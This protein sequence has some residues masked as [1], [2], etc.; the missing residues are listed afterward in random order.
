MP[1]HQYNSVSGEG[2]DISNRFLLSLT[3]FL[4]ILLSLPH[5]QSV[6]EEPFELVV[7]QH[8]L[9]PGAHLVDVLRKTFNIPDH[10]IFNEYLNL[11]HE[12]NPE[13]KDLSNLADHQ[14]ILIPLALPPKNEN[15]RIVIM[16]PGR[17][18]KAVPS[19]P[20]QKKPVYS[21]PMHE[22]TTP[23]EKIDLTRILSEDFIPLLDESDAAVQQEGTHEFPDFEGSQLSVNT[24]T[25]PI[26]QLKNNTFII[27]DPLNRFPSELKDVIQSNWSNYKF[28]PSGKEQGLESI[29]DQIIKDMSFFKA[30][31]GGEP[32]VRG[33]DVLV[34]ISADWLICPDSE[35]QDVFVV[36]LIYSPEH[37]TLSQIKNYLES[38]SI[39]IIDVRLYK[40]GEEET[41]PLGETKEET[42]EPLSEISKLDISDK[43]DFLDTLLMLAGEEYLKNVPI[44]I[45]S[46]DSNGLAL[47]VTIDRT[48]VKN[49][50]KH[51]IYVQDKSPKLLGLLKKQGFPLLKLSADDDAVST[52]KKVLDFLKIR[53]QSPMITF[54]ASSAGKKSKISIHIP[55]ILFEKSGRNVFLT[56]LELTQS[57]ITFL[58]HK[59]ILPAIYQ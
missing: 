17:I 27:L 19:T 33:K 9:L 4:F 59:N 58:T 34:K 5:N 22:K 56:H 29:L 49:G 13:V 6:A 55:G 32:L 42:K 53:T 23:V 37:K 54:A 18:T 43:L 50:K 36:N 28:I 10:L 12:I 45:Y 11:I 35:S 51:L 25:Y 48:F 20:E 7:E 57:L 21:T 47:Q 2:M 44:S 24:A 52:I 38:Q 14:M 16:E 1:N 41:L 39:N 40:P 15:Y 3:L 30:I 26:V 31:K 46:R 8:V